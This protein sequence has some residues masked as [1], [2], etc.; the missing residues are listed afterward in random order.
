M[1]ATFGFLVGYTL[2]HGPSADGPRFRAAGEGMWGPGFLDV[3]ANPWLQIGPLYIFLLGG[4]SRA[5]EFVGTSWF[6]EVALVA[7]QG[8]LDVFLVMITA[9]ALARRRGRPHLVARWVVGVVIGLGTTQV[10]ASRW[11]HPEDVLLAVALVWC[12]VLATTRGPVWAGLLLGLAGG[13][14]QWALL[15]VGTLAAGRLGRRLV[16]GILAAA[17]VTVVLYLPFMVFGD[18]RLFDMHWTAQLGQAHNWWVQ[19]RVVVGW[20]LRLV[21][22]GLASLAGFAVAWRRPHLP[23]VAAFAAIGARVMTEAAPLNYYLAPLDVVFLLWLWTSARAGSIRRRLV[24]TLLVPVMDSAARIHLRHDA[25]DTPF[26]ALV[27]I[28]IVVGL[29]WMVRAERPRRGADTVSA[30]HV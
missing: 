21:Q 2:Q 13:F 5:L 28:L 29:F 19:G 23:E 8:A 30:A 10:A 3:Y 4:A 22:G 26:W 11:G 14:K 9:R 25:A 27:T 6:A 24:L 16:Y 1:T 15:G 17:G 12:G 18:F 7:A 20:P